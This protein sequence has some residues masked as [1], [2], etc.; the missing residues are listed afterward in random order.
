MGCECISPPPEFDVPPPPDPSLIWNLLFDEA[1]EK[2]TEACCAQLDGLFRAIQLPNSER[3][4][5]AERYKKKERTRNKRK[6]EYPTDIILNTSEW[7]Y[8]NAEEN[9]TSMKAGDLLYGSTGNDFLVHKAIPITSNLLRNY[10]CR[11]NNLPLNLMRNSMQRSASTLRLR[12]STDGYCTIGKMYEEIPRNRI[13]NNI[14]TSSNPW[15]STRE[16]K[17]QTN[18][19][20][21]SVR[22]PPPTCRPPPPPPEDSP[23]SLDSTENSLDKEFNATPKRST[24]DEKSRNSANSGENGHES[25]YGTAPNRSWNS[26]VVLHEQK[27]IP[28]RQSEEV[29]RR[30]TPL[31]IYAH[32]TNAHPMTYV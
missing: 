10:S 1:N 9:N 15:T 7:P 28:F 11:P 13:F 17:L 5:E 19:G 21:S 18:Y 6:S 26:P 27:R 23:I 29:P 2:L 3:D 22:R 14:Q 12:G 16:C 30:Q 32:R 31:A 8:T 25:G 4:N 20:I 24:D